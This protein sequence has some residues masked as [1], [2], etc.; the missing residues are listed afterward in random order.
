MTNVGEEHRPV[1]PSNTPDEYCTHPK[2]QQHGQPRNSKKRACC[3]DCNIGA[4]HDEFALGCDRTHRWHVEVVAL[5]IDLTK[6][7]EHHDAK[8]TDYRYI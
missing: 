7:I 8:E 4:G 3:R 2:S 5:A 6:V 1:I